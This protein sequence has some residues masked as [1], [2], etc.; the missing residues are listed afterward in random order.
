MKIVLRGLNFVRFDYKSFSS[1]E[2]EERRKG[3]EIMERPR[4]VVPVRFLFYPFRNFRGYLIV[5]LS[6]LE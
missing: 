2:R 4:P 5:M 1:L 3:E 6:L